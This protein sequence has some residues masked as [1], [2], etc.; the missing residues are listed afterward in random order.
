MKLIL[1][2]TLEQKRII[3]HLKGHAMVNAGPGCAKTSTLALRVQHMLDQGYEPRSIVILTFGKALSLDIVDTLSKLI[4]PAAANQI[5]VS[6]IHSFAYKLV[7]KFY[8]SL[9]H[10]EKPTVFNP[11]SR[12]R[13]LKR[14]VKG[15][16]VKLKELKQAFNQYDLYSGIKSR[17][18]EDMLGNDK[19]KLAKKSYRHYSKYKL[20]KNAV[21]FNDM[22]VGAIKLLK[23]RTNSR[24]T[25]LGYQHLMVDELQDIDRNQKDLLLLL[26]PRMKST[27]MVGDPLQ[28][29]F[30]W[31]QSLPRYWHDIEKTLT[32]KK[33]ALTRSF[34]APR[35]ALA[36]INNLGREINPDA[37]LL[38]SKF[39][40]EIPKLLEFV[41]QD[42][43]HTYMAEEIERLLACGV[44]VYKIAIL[45]KTRK[46]LSQTALA[47]R[48]R[49]ITVTERYGLSANNID[50]QKHKTHLLALIQLTQLEQLRIGRSSKTQTREQ[51]TLAR[52]CIENLWLPKKTV[53][54]LQERLTVKPKALLSIK[55]YNSNYDRI[56]NLSKAVRKA[57]GLKNVESALQC[58][59]DASKSILKDRD[60][61][62]YKLRLR[63]LTE[64]KIMARNCTSLDNINHGWF[65][66][67]ID[68]DVNS[69]IQLM[70]VHAAKGQEWDYVFILNVVEGIIPR[71]QATEAKSLEENRVFYV[72]VTRHHK[73]LYVLQTPTPARKVTSKICGSKARS[74]S[75][76]PVIYDEPSS[77]IDIDK[78]GLLFKSFV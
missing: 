43:Q 11:Q 29:I 27:V 33:F 68:K 47:L 64:I 24:S 17:K 70:T 36:L 25:L 5:T 52:N 12:E 60:E 21:D 7:N 2:P 23:L 14:R 51:Q 71:H 45:G 41:D 32:P 38:T 31:R 62:H 8:K 30:G 6:T 15:T 28:S 16:G 18:I 57:A 69:G 46:E 59:I 75:I 65:K 61:H 26:A 44:E 1:K 35:Q 67:S 73:A 22:V 20:R 19:A 50:H 42:Q 66:P 9:G 58:L 78:Q 39:D 53:R 49:D 10:D 72:A 76:K 74:G 63:D 4:G 56:N 13:F 54:F 55:S 34:R 37:P 40:G 48:A 3:N 77:F